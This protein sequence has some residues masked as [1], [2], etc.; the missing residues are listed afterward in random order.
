MLDEVLGP[1]RSTRERNIFIPFQYC[2]KQDTGTKVSIAHKSNGDDDNL[3][4]GGVE[5]SEDDESSD[6][7][8]SDAE[9]DVI[10]EVTFLDYVD[11]KWKTEKVEMMKFSKVEWMLD[12]IYLLG[13][14][15]WHP[16]MMPY[17]LATVQK[18][19]FW[20]IVYYTRGDEGT[21]SNELHWP[22]ALE[23][24]LPMGGEWLTLSK[25]Y[26]KKDRPSVGDAEVDAD[27]DADVDAEVDVDAGWG[28]E[29]NSAKWNGALEAHGPDGWEWDNGKKR[30]CKKDNGEDDGGTGGGWDC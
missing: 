10:Y 13:I 16:G 19:L 25:R 30:Y 1:R 21:Q 11:K 4:G 8:V 29:S 14:D 23:E 6:E 24:L 7:F 9:D 27:V 18:H 26:S 2:H 15:S 12:K 20:S 28:N 17:N 5:S 3:L 22:E